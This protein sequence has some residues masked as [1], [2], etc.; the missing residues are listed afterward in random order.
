LNVAYWSVIRGAPNAE[1]AIRFLNWYLDH[2]EIQVA[3]ARATG[4]SPATRSAMALLSPD[5]QREQPGYQD[6]ARSIVAV[7]YGWIAA[8]NDRILR[9][10]TEWISR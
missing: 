2:P 4:G 10:W 3:F 6:N 1:N 5:E 7:D 9:R 8:N